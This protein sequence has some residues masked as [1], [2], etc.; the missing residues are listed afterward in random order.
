MKITKALLAGC[1]LTLL[2]LSLV[3]PVYAEIK[4][5]YEFSAEYEASVYRENLKKLTLTG[6]GATDTLMIA[7]SQLGY[8]EGN[9]DADFGGNN[10][11]G[12]RN[13]VEYNR[14]Y[15]KVDN[16]EGN[17][18]SYGY[19]WCASFVN[20]CLRQAKVD[21]NIAGGEISCTRWINNF[22]K[23]NK[24]W[25]DSPAYG[26]TYVPVP[27]DLI[28]FSNQYVNTTSSHIGLV[29]YADTSTVY[30]IEGNA[31]GCVGLHTYNLSDSYV[32]GYGTPNY[33][34]DGY[35]TYDYSI[36]TH[37]PGIH[38]VTASSLNIRAA[39][40]TN[41]EILGTLKKGQ[42]IT[43]LSFE[44]G[45]AQFLL[46]DGKMAFV[47]ASYLVYVADIPLK[48]Y[49]IVYE[50]GDAGGRITNQIKTEGFDLTLSSK[51]P[52]KI[53]MN[54]LG[55]SLTPNPAP[56][57]TPDFQ[58]GDV[59]TTDAPLTLYPIFAVKQ[60]TITFLDSD[61][62]TVLLTLVCNHDELPAPPEIPDTESDGIRRILEGWSAP[63]EK[64]TEDATYIAVYRE[65]ELP[66]ET[67]LPEETDNTTTQLPKDEP[68]TT[69]G[70]SAALLPSLPIFFLFIPATLLLFKRRK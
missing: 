28:F 41:A 65:E 39:A 43:A 9:S 53:G 14:L 29:L 15:G 24:K 25:Q 56:D 42:T 37:R 60:Y 11:N 58:P 8:H 67:I 54:F 19:A 27:G 33:K 7:L 44:N 20:W 30:T 23:P 57:A 26:G 48:T 68:L 38:I 45:F 49:D 13:F 2:S 6:N 12:G 22:L 50:I 46:E 52:W 10:E 18:V 40:S 32:I 36:K 21:K 34:T 31:G 61:G 47:S 5:S 64:A 1:L 3:L 70:C 51:A 59:Y 66:P 63:I 4:P 55:W 62:T 35:D 16:L 17:G 69:E